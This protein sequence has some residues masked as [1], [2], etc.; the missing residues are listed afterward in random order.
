MKD[1]ISVFDPVTKY[2][3]LAENFYTGRTYDVK[4][5]PLYNTQSNGDIAQFGNWFLWR[6]WSSSWN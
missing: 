4:N 1:R 5:N 2:L 3:F 6:G